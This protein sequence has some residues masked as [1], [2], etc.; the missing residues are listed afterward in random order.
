[1]KFELSR[2]FTRM[3]SLNYMTFSCK[4]K[5]FLTGALKACILR[6]VRT[7]VRLAPAILIMSSRRNASWF[8]RAERF[9]SFRVAFKYQFLYRIPKSICK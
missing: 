3:R 9:K 4:V 6:E 1:M 8:T 5:S 7:I 2:V